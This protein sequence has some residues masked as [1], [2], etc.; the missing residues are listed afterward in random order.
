MS[1]KYLRAM[2]PSA[3]VAL[4]LTGCHV[5]PK[6]QRLPAL[7]Q[8]PPAVYKEAP[9]AVATPTAP[10]MA[11]PQTASAGEWKVADPQDAM[12]R[13]KWWE[14]YK[15]AELNAL[16][17][18]LAINNQTIKVYFENFMQARAIVGEARSQLYPTVTLGPSFARSQASANSGG[19][20]GSKSAGNLTTL[21]FNASWEP[22]LWGRIHGQLREAQY[23][24]QVS[25]AD[26]EG[27]R[28]T[29]Q[30]SLAEYFFEIRGQDALID[31][32]KQT[33]A[34]DEKAVELTRSQYETGVGTEIAVVEAQNTL[35]N[36]QSALTNLGVARAQY[37]HAIAVLT[38]SNPSTFSIAVKPLDAVPPTIPI[39][40]PS[41]LLERRPDIAASERTMASAN[42]AIGVAYTA[43][44]PTVTL[45]GEAGLASSTLSHLFDWPSRVWSIGTGLSETVYEGGLQR[46]TA[47]QF[48]AIYNGDVASY[49]QTVLAAF[50]QVEDALAAERIL[51]TQIGQQ[52][53]AAATAQKLVE[54]ET[55]RYETGVDPYIDVVT[56]QQALL[57]DRQALAMLHTQAMTASVQ[58]IEALGGGWDNS[59]LPTP[60]QVTKKLTATEASIQK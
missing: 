53:Q 7:A 32:Y 21:P 10:A 25:A 4:L 43:F 12:L 56:T 47:V 44:F 16:E 50:Q 58:L 33:V 8:A 14:I 60:E 57:A 30:A 51:S 42:A 55:A 24:A 40:V 11:T 39:G 46:A 54:L 5:G 28:L 23:N 31:V 15:D 6:Y 48:A 22:D 26:L 17:E 35:Q 37:E 20:G 45:S 52:Q 36:A 49:R 34:D 13:G 41:Q 3:V 38:G 9:A 29:E 19:S 1:K 18:K 2:I 27:E 59:Q